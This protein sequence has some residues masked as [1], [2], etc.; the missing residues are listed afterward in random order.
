[1]DNWLCLL[2]ATRSHDT[3]Q[4]TAPRTLPTRAVLHGVIAV[5]ALQQQTTRLA[6]RQSLRSPRR[7][8]RGRIEAIDSTHGFT[9]HYGS[10]RRHRRGRIEAVTRRGTTRATLAVLHG[11]IAVA[12]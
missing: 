9:R 8:R 4:L 1:M 7:H 6:D 12:A 5:A 10:P 2:G 3:P 11:V